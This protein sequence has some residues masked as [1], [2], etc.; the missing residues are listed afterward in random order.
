MIRMMNHRMV[1]LDGPEPFLA[2]EEPFVAV[3]TV[4]SERLKA[5]DHRDIKLKDLPK[6]LPAIKRGQGS[7]S[8]ESFHKD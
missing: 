6:S 3:V 8:G 5:A 1:D 2:D 4:D 7:C